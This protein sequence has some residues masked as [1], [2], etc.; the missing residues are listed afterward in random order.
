MCSLPLLQAN[1][2]N[3]VLL[4]FFLLAALVAAVTS[5]LYYRRTKANQHAV[6]AGKQSSSCM[7]SFSDECGHCLEDSEEAQVR[8]LSTVESNSSEELCILKDLGDLV[9]NPCGV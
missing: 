2:M 4:G 8:T 5:A 7:G 3:F 9:G 6:G 1:I